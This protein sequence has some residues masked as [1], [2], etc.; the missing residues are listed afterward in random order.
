MRYENDPA[1]LAANVRKHGVWFEEAEEFEWE[2]A[3]VVVDTRKAYGEPR[4]LA[5]GYIGNRLHLMA[6][7]LRESVVRIISLRRANSREVR[8]YAEA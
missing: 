1:K 2:T 5:T 4:L 3:L 7:T 8:R 6:F